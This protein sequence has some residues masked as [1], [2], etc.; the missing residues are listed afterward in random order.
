MGM[1]RLLQLKFPVHQVTATPVK[2]PDTQK[3]TP[4]KNSIM[5]SYCYSNEKAWYVEGYSSEKF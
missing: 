5:S 3:A 2:N 1:L 4:V